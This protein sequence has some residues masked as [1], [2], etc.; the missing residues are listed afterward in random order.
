MKTTVRVVGNSVEAWLMAF[1]L[2][3]GLATRNA[4]VPEPMILLVDVPVAEPMSF[5]LSP[6]DLEFFQELAISERE[7]IELADG[8]FTLGYNYREIDD[9]QERFFAWGDCGFTWRSIG[10]QHVWRKFTNLNGHEAFDAFCFAKYCA[11]LN[12]FVHRQDNQ[13]SILSQLR[14]GITVDTEKL[15]ILLRGRSETEGVEVEKSLKVEPVDLEV[16]FRPQLH[17]G[18]ELDYTP[19]YNSTLSCK[20]PLTGDTSG[21]SNVLR[22]DFGWLK[23]DFL[24][25][26]V[27][28]TAIYNASNHSAEFVREQLVKEVGNHNWYESLYPHQLTCD[29]WREAKVRAGTHAFGLM[30]FVHS[31]CYSLH[32]QLDTLLQLIPDASVRNSGADL[33]ELPVDHLAKEYNEFADVLLERSAEIRQLHCNIDMTE[34]AD[35]DIK[36]QQVKQ[37]FEDSGVVKHLTE[38]LLAED[39]WVKLLFALNVTPRS[40]TPL[41]DAKPFDEVAA[42]LRDGVKALQVAAE[43]LPPLA[44]YRAHYLTKSH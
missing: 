41:L 43:K 29:M 33:N 39:D 30:P 3:R 40:Y 9:T 11:Q 27:V 15:K 20:V 14:H 34:S 4:I 19:V 32:R 1:G 2:K 38:S 24:G 16:D 26:S 7:L 5:H 17:S 44:V 18:Q 35:V 31:S 36:I 37:L 10:F 28:Y 21:A 25:S 42:R 22:K 8:Q 23:V 13:R 6:K 12:H